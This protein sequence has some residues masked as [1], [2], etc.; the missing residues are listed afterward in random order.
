VTYSIGVRL[1]IEDLVLNCE[2]VEGWQA[3]LLSL[4]EE[5]FLG[6]DLH[7]IICSFIVFQ[8]QRPL[9][10]YNLSGL[11]YVCSLCLKWIRDRVDK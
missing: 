8:P 5:I 6:Q 1:C 2:R 10:S 3:T 4:V 7:D 11:L 9:L